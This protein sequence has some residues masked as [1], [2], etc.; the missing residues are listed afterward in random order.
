[1]IDVEIVDQMFEYGRETGALMGFSIFDRRVLFPIAQLLQAVRVEANLELNED[2][3]HA[4]VAQG[5][6]HLLPRDESGELGAPLYVP[7]RIKLLTDLKSRG[8]DARE[9]RLY[10]DYEEGLID[11]VLTVEDFEYIDDDLSVLIKHTQS[12]IESFE[13]RVKVAAGEEQQQTAELEQSR[14]QLAW[15]RRLQ[16]DGIPQN[17]EPRIAKYAY[18]VRALN[19][20]IRLDMVDSDRAKLRQGYSPTV[21]F[22]RW[23]SRPFEE[24]KFEGIMWDSTVRSAVAHDESSPAPMIRVP[25]FL[26]AGDRVSPTKTMRPAEYERLWKEHDLDS[27]LR[28]WSAVTGERRC[29]NCFEPLPANASE[30]KRFCNEKCR[31]AAKQRQANQDA[32]Q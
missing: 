16:R 7:S 17:V 29:S 32:D 24:H 12:R 15:L 9:L 8:Y 11:C 5:W 14:R 18:R 4:C 19:E 31:N 1:M 13:H 10:A 2:E 30:R 25:G 22:R 28:A 27:Y 20:M 21:Q 3:L 26:L 23:S 6:F